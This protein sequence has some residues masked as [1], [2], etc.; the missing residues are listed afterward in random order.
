MTVETGSGTGQPK[1]KRI[2]GRPE[3]WAIQ[4]AL[5]LCGLNHQRGQAERA[6]SGSR[7]LQ[8]FAHYIEQHEEPPIEPLQTEGCE[9]VERA[10]AVM[11]RAQARSLSKRSKAGEMKK[12]LKLAL[13]AIGMAVLVMIVLPN[14]RALFSTQAATGVCSKPLASSL[15]KVDCAND[16]LIAL[17]E[18]TINA[19]EDNHMRAAVVVFR[20][21]K[22]SSTTETLKHYAIVDVD[23]AASSES[24]VLLVRTFYTSNIEQ[25]SPKAFEDFFD[26]WYSPEPA[27]FHSRLKKLICRKLSTR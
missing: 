18:S 24:Q 6:A 5:D 19:T 3:L 2:S 11:Q 10:D 22:V 27:R 21:P 20:Q 17:D 8:A 1:R 14:L 26:F 7:V 13:L 23:C 12:W 25:K 9:A 16:A 4:R 15:R